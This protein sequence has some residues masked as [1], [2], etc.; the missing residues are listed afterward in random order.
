MVR[1][2]ILIELVDNEPSWVDDY[3]GAIG[4]GMCKGLYHS[5]WPNEVILHLDCQDLESLNEAVSQAI[6]QLK[7]VKRVLTCAVITQ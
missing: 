2:Y 7:G 1:A 4:L 3:S 6:P 5:L